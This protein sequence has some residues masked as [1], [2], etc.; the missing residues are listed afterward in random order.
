M[1]NKDQAVCI[2]TVDYSETSQVATFFAR[3]TGKISVIAKGSKRHKSSFGGPLEILTYG[4]IVFL[5]RNQS[6]LATLTEFEQKPALT[7]LSKNLTAL[8]CALFAA[9]LLNLLTEEYDPHTQLFDSIIEFLENI[10][11]TKKTEQMLMLLISFQLTLLTQTG[12]SPILNLCSNCSMPLKNSNHLYFS[13]SSN[14]LICKDCEVSFYDKVKL[15]PQAANFI[16]NLKQLDKADKNTL[17]EIEKILITHFTNLLS[18]PP[19]MAKHIL[20]LK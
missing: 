18:K 9:E 19:K 8:N 17:A 11:K 12:F 1:L 7:N 13:S 14:G 3:Q 20:A 4:Q 5:Q 10:Q 6:S 16:T 2:R 15:T